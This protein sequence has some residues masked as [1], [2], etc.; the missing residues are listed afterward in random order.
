MAFTKTNRPMAVKAIG[1]NISKFR[2]DLAIQRNLVWDEAK[3]MR[4][5]LFVHSLATDY[6]I[7]PVFVQDFGDNEFWVI[8]GKQRLTTIGEL[9]SDKLVMA[10]NTPKVYIANM[11][12]AEEEFDISG[13]KFSQFPEQVQDAISSTHITIYYFKNMS[14]EERDEMFLRLNNGVSLTKME[15]TRVSAGSGIMEFVTEIAENP[16]FFTSVNMSDKARNRFVDQEM[17]LQIMALVA[18]NSEA[19][20]LSSKAI[21]EFVAD[22]KENEYSKENYDTIRDTTIY[23]NQA[24]PEKEKFLKKVHTPIIFLVAIK[25]EREGLTPQSFA[26]FIKNFFSPKTYQVGGAY[27]T[28]ASAGSTKVANVAI[29][30]K[31]LTSVYNAFKI[32]NKRTA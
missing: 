4:K 15:L 12:G 29:R 6:P 3:D 26:K 18:N 21:S 5:S 10:K 7:L 17:I 11:D 9:Y 20:D 25:A 16:F 24:F 30:I 32:A 22:I 23:L 31:E 19:V 13:L 27:G 2:F 1:K 8:D 28:G 14:D